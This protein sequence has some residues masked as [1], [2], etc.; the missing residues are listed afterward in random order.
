MDQAAEGGSMG[1]T[2][3]SVDDVI[4]AIVRVLGTS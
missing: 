2:L 3:T 4:D 1:R